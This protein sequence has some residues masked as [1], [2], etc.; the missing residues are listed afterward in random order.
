MI[1]IRATSLSR[2]KPAQ[3]WSVA[4]T[5]SSIWTRAPDSA[6]PER[7][8]SGGSATPLSHDPERAVASRDRD[9]ALS[10]GA[11]QGHVQR[12]GQRHGPRRRMSVVV[13]KA[14]AGDGHPGTGGGEEG[15]L[16]SRRPVMR[17]LEHVGSQVG[18]AGQNRLLPGRLN[19]TSEQ[20]PDTGNIHGKHQAAVVLVGRFGSLDR[21]M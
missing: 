1:P 20:Q 14:G 17:D 9:R 10:I 6:K 19:V 11:E 18:P 3:L 12:A 16:L 2:V 7:K 4:Q 13:V 5:C 21:R 8:S 15:W